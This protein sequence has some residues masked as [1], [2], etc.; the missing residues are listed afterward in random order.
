MLPT[1]CSGNWCGGRLE[2]SEVGPI[3]GSQVNRPGLTPTGFRGTPQ[4]G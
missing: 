2:E 1:R 4:Q 3:G